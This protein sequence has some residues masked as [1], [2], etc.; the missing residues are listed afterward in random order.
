[1]IFIYKTL[2]HSLLKFV[3]LGWGRVVGDA[4]EPE[5]SANAPRVELTE[6]GR[7]VE[8]ELTSSIS[9]HYPMIE[10]QDH[11]IM[12]EH[13]HALVAVKGTIVSANGRETHLG[14]VIAGFK[15][16][17]NRRYWEMTGTKGVEPYS[18]RMIA[19]GE[20]TSDIARGEPSLAGRGTDA[21]KGT[22]T[23]N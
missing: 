19:R 10:V 23:V 21:G 7:M 2:F 4:N 12:P 22:Q 13:L 17:C 15:K 1:M 8:E 6:V 9:L 5:G 14:Q 16:G 18:L 11:I 20:A 3:F